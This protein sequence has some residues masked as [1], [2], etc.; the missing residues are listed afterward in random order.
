MVNIS[1]QGKAPVVSQ[2]YDAFLANLCVA[3]HGG[4]TSYKTKN[5]DCMQ[6][7]QAS[8]Q[9]YNLLETETKLWKKIGDYQV[10]QTLN[11]LMPY[12][13]DTTDIQEILGIGDG[14]K[15]K[16]SSN[17]YYKYEFVLGKKFRRSFFDSSLQTRDQ[18]QPTLKRNCITPFKFM[19]T[20]R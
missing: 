10:R 17:I 5:L 15:I 13:F 7:L 14:S 19:V 12:K 20:E 18:Q 11:R 4:H 9:K 6:E 16:V 8:N 3:A 1:I 2:H